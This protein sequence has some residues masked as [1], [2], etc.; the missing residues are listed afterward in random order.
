MAQSANVP[1]GTELAAKQEFNRN[2]GTNPA[3]F[4]P[5][6]IE[7]VP[8]GNVARQVFEGLVTSDVKGNLKPGVA[9]S[10]EHSDDFKTW[11]F[12]LRK[13][14]K[15]SNGDLGGRSAFS[16]QSSIWMCFQNAMP[17]CR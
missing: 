17:N 3:S 13:D 6:K 10:W 16:N 12:H 7:G 9:E 8:E 1:A 2:N 5:Q 15:L 11:T 4:D 14:A